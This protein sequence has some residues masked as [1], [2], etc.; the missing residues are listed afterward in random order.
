MWFRLTLEFLT[1]VLFFQS[2]GITLPEN[3]SLVTNFSKQK[4]LVT[5]MTNLDTNLKNKKLLVTK[6]VTIINKI[7][8]L[9]TKFVIN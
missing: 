1:H 5:V 8:K 3:V 9:V 6:L 2:I 4:L 7:F